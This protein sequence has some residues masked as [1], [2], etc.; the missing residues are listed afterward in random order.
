MTASPPSNQSPTQPVEHTKPAQSLAD[1][2]DNDAHEEGPIPQ[3]DTNTDTSQTISNEEEH[4]NAMMNPF[5]LDAN[6][7]GAVDGD[8]TAAAAAE[9][10][11]YDYDAAIS[12]RYAFG[13]HHDTMD[14]EN[15]EL[16][17]HAEQ[18]GLTSSME[19]GDLNS[20]SM[21]ELMRSTSDPRRVLKMVKDFRRDQRRRR[22]ERALSSTG[23]RS[24]VLFCLSS[25]CDITEK[26]GIILVLFIASIFILLYNVFSDS[27]A[28]QIILS[29]GASAL[30]LR[31]LYRPIYWLLWGRILEQ[32]RLAALKV[33]DGVNGEMAMCGNH[34]P[35]PHDDPDA[36]DCEEMDE[37]TGKYSGVVV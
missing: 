34:I 37:E 27:F 14:A 3:G 10:D 35:L 8:D 24:R 32:R 33:F 28:K 9:L 16:Y 21:L 11:D 19:I 36:N 26:K 25:W 7:D 23:I 12:R 13:D 17:N 18:N 15:A 30:G 1:D 31:L 22:A 6:R 20:N 5:V 2:N 4:I 29:V